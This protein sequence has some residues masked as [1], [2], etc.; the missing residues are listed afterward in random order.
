[1]KPSSDMVADH[2]ILPTIC[3]SVEISMINMVDPR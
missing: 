1:M 2:S 3:T